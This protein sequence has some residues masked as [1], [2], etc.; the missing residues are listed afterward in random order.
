MSDHQTHFWTSTTIL[1]VSVVPEHSRFLNLDTIVTS[2]PW[3]SSLLRLLCSFSHFRIYFYGRYVSTLTHC[4]DIVAKDGI[5]GGPGQADKYTQ[6]IDQA[7]YLSGPDCQPIPP[8]SG[9]GDTIDAI[10]KKGVVFSANQRKKMHQKSEAIR[11]WT[12]AD[13]W[14]QSTWPRDASGSASV[15]FGF[16]V[17]DE[18]EEELDSMVAAPPSRGKRYLDSSDDGGVPPKAVRENP[19]VEPIASVS[20]L[21]SNIEEAELDCILFL[22]AKFCK[23]CKTINPMYTRMARQAHDTSS[24]IVFAKAEASGKW[25]KALGRFLGVEA[26]PAFVLFKNG[27]RFGSPLS[28]SKLPSRKIDRAIQLLESGAE[29][30]P[31]ILAEDE[32]D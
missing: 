30:D 6:R 4:Q 14:E 9:I 23:T 21:Q 1:T 27:E 2:K 29:W 3:P 5:F 22:S 10:L 16:P 18:D 28:T 11:G 12:L 25:G 26:V 17:V 19:Y 8:P 20:G 13:F 31:S 32:L 24:S 7:A 15:R